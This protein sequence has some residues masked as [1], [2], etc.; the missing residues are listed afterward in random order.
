MFDKNNFAQILKNISETYENQRDFAKKSDI[1]R[2]YLSQYMNMK[3]DE[4][5]KPK[6]L[7]KL[8]DASKGLITYEELMIICGYISNIRGNR[9]KSCRLSRNLSLEEVA[10]IIGTTPRKLNY[11][12]NG[13]DYNM[14]IEAT[15][16]LANLY[17]V[18]FNW[19]MGSINP[20]Y[21]SPS[22]NFN[23]STHFEF[24]SEDDAMYPLLDIGD[25]ATVYKQNTIDETNP[26]SNNAGTYLIEIDNQQTIRRFIESQDKTYYTLQGMNMTCKPINIKKE[27]LQDRITILGKV[28]KVENKSAFK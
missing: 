20:K 21:L 3:I 25:M 17:N 18:D 9:L 13:H 16:K 22:N 11:W 8:A 2:T 24:V 4:P 28:I 26:S 6:I 14:D 23:S 1:N 15:D 19:L 10:N 5:P 27:E 12:E 7:E